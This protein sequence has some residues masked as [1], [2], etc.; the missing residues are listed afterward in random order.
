M[1]NIRTPWP[2]SGGTLED[3]LKAMKRFNQIFVAEK[4]GRNKI[5]RGPYEREQISQEIKAGL[6]ELVW[7]SYCGS[8]GKLT[9]FRERATGRRREESMRVGEEQAWGS[10]EEVR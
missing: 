5:I 10:R 8:C 4:K 9:V 7:E 1:P 2:F 6:W 3:A